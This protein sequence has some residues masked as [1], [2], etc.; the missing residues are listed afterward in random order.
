MKYM[1]ET[2]TNHHGYEYTV[3]GYNRETKRYTVLFTHNGV[4]KAVSGL[5]VRYN[6][7]SE[8]PLFAKPTKPTERRMKDLYL[9]MLARLNGRKFYED[10]ELDPRWETFAGF[11]ETLHMVEGYE[12]WLNS[13]GYALDKDLKGMNMY[14]PE[15]CIFLTRSENASLPRKSSKH[16]S[17]PV[18]TWLKSQHG[19][20]FKII[21]KDRFWSTI[22]YEETGE[23]RRIH[24]VAISTNKV[25]KS[26]KWE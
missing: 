17:Y 25:G 9:S 22:R 12:L 14:G 20:W 26:T 3:I 24:S 5:L 6:S 7:V 11:C 8:K 21:D 16:K 10:V 2:R 19:Q 15:S 1:N 23:I 18:G 4:T 13:T